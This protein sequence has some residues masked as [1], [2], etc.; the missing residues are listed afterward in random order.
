MELLQFKSNV[1]LFAGKLSVAVLLAQR[2]VSNRNYLDDRFTHGD[3]K[4]SNLGR[5]ASFGASKG[6]AA[7][8][9]RRDM[10][11]RIDSVEYMQ[12]LTL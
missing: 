2:R 7:P 12:H 11:W 9:I 6:C 5:D 1:L 4:S 8:P 10:I 3:L